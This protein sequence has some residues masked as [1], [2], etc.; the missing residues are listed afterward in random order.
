VVL[1]WMSLIGPPGPCFVKSVLKRVSCVSLNVLLHLYC[2]LMSFSL[3]LR[4]GNVRLDLIDFGRLFWVFLCVFI[5]KVFSLSV[6]YEYI[7]Q[8]HF[9]NTVT[10]R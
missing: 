1:E 8:L 4:L 2:V 9:T 6:E 10:T 3:N 5:S 7:C